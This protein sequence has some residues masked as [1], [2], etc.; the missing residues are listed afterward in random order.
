MTYSEYEPSFPDEAPERKNSTF[1]YALVFCAVIGVVLAVALTV[2]FL[3]SSGDLST[4][5]GADFEEKIETFL[6]FNSGLEKAF[7]KDVRGAALSTRDELL[8]STHASSEEQLTAEHIAVAVASFFEIGK[9]KDIEEAEE[10]NDEDVDSIALAI[11]ELDDILEN[12]DEIDAFSGE[13]EK[14]AYKEIVDFYSQARDFLQ[15]LLLYKEEYD[16]RLLSWL[17]A[18]QMTEDTESYIALLEKANE[19]VSDPERYGPYSDGWYLEEYQEILESTV[20][21]NHQAVNGFERVDIPSDFNDQEILAKIRNAQLEKYK[22]RE[23][24]AA[25]KLEIVRNILKGFE[26]VESLEAVE[27]ENTA[28]MLYNEA[29]VTEAY[30]TLR[31]HSA[32]KDS[33]D[34]L[35]SQ[36]N[37]VRAEISALSEASEQYAFLAKDFS[38]E[39]KKYERAQEDGLKEEMERVASRARETA[40]EADPS[41]T[42][43]FSVEEGSTNMR[44]SINVWSGTADDV[45]VFLKDPKGRFYKA[46]ERDSYENYVL[47]TA[48]E[49]RIDEPLAGVWMITI[50]AGAENEGVNTL[51]SVDSPLKMH[52][53]VVSQPED[54]VAYAL[55][56][57]VVYEAYVTNNGLVV[58]GSEMEGEVT[59]YEGDTGEKHLSYETFQLFDDGT[60]YDT[61]ADDGIY[62]GAVT[63]T[64]VPGTLCPEI[65]AFGSKENGDPYTIWQS[66]LGCEILR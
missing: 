59:F 54:G 51:V 31:N 16:G 21:T 1:V 40:S 43:F 49:Y 8:A 32:L 4:P 7:T 27:A 46:G 15:Q 60:G 36:N 63:K 62:T 45:E 2:Y 19:K 34:K 12:S 52:A 44:I 58:H 37:L 26:S 50:Q 35:I 18:T 64:Q 33:F 65:R 10:R 55:G 41:V 14:R 5:I 66:L 61:H 47:D 25:Q 6:L 39:I 42:K 13:S 38:E 48:L 56:D 30:F 57:P 53:S 24:V 22:L 29:R 28:G 9:T 17:P 23:A 3:S 20:E 11:S